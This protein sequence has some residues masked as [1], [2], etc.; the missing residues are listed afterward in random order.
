VREAAK[1]RSNPELPDNVDISD[2]PSLM[3][4]GPRWFESEDPMQAWLGN[5]ML[6]AW[7]LFHIWV[8]SPHTNQS[9]YNMHHY[10]SLH[11]EQGE[12]GY[13]LIWSHFIDHSINSADLCYVKRGEACSNSI[14]ELSNANRALDQPIRNGPE[15]GALSWPYGRNEDRI[16]GSWE[17]WKCSRLR[18]QSLKDSATVVPQPGFPKLASS[19]RRGDPDLG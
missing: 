19:P 18:H 11:Q 13:D 9:R 15:F 7:I 8:P 1:P 16:S 14:K 12:R 5:T 6:G 4:T 10:R 17:G 2:V 3:A